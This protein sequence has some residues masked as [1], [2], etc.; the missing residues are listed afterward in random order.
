MCFANQLR[1]DPTFTVNYSRLSI[2]I[3]GFDATAMT[4]ITKIILNSCK[5]KLT[6]SGI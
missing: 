5:F 2:L 6:G 1:I 4:L 3:R